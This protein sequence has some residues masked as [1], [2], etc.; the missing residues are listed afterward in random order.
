MQVALFMFAPDGQRRRFPL[1][2]D[3]TIVGRREDCDLRIPLTEVSRKHC[4]IIKDELGLRLEDLGSSNG[5][6]HNGSR[7]QESTIQPGDR[8]QIGPVVFTAQI[9]GQPAEDDI[10]PPAADTPGDAD[11]SS[12]GAEAI[13][14]VLSPASEL[15]E[16]PPDRPASPAEIAD[17][18]LHDDSDDGKHG[19]IDFE[20]VSPSPQGE[21]P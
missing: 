21:K 16:Q 1:N 13:D 8:I 2:R 9:D 15:P 17:S 14:D 10:R 7:I 20:G 5:T 19:L 11:S 18:L 12:V 4:R 6:F 3:V